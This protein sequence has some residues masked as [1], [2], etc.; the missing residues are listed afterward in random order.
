MEKRKVL[1]WCVR[2]EGGGERMGEEEVFVRRQREEE[3]ETN[4]REGKARVTKEEH[5][6][7]LRMRHLRLIAYR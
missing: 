7:R 3:R 5:Q 4:N 6:G 1:M 2:R